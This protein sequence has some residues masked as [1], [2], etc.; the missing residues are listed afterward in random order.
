MDP[1]RWERVLGLCQEA[2][3]RPE[4]S[5]MAFVATGCDGDAELRDEV[6]SLLAVQTRGQ[7]LDDL[8]TP[9]LAAV[10]G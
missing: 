9:W 2:L 4:A 8:P 7:A 1:A 5:R 10:A 6:V 3:A